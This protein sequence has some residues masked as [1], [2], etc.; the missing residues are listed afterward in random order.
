MLREKN[1]PRKRS[2][3]EIENHSEIT[4]KT[5]TSASWVGIGSKVN[6]HPKEYAH[7]DEKSTNNSVFISFVNRLYSQRNERNFGPF[8]NKFLLY[9]EQ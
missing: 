3:A 2:F 5:C 6:E 9:F 1:N 4:K 7:I 8:A